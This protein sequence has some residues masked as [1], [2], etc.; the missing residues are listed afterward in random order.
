MGSLSLEEKKEKIDSF[1]SRK[2][3]NLF[4]KS[5]TKDEF[6]SNLEKEKPQKIQELFHKDDKAKNYYQSQVDEYT[7]KFV[8]ENNRREEEKRKKEIQEEQKNIETIIETNYNEAKNK[9]NINEFINFF[10]QNEEIKNL[11]SKK[12][13][14]MDYYN[15]LISNYSVKYLNEWKEKQNEIDSFFNDNYQT[16]F[17]EIKNKEELQTKLEEEGNKFSGIEYFENKKQEKL[18]QFENEIE[19]IKHKIDNHFSDYEEESYKKDSDIEFGNFF[20]DKKKEIEEYLNKDEINNYYNDELRKNKNKFKKYLDDENQKQELNQRKE[21]DQIFT[22]QYQNIFDES[23]NKGDLKSKLEETGRRFSGIKYFENKKEEK[24]NQYDNEIEQ[25]KSIIKSHFSEHYDTSLQ[26]NTEND[27]INFFNNKKN[28]IQRYLTKDVISNLYNNELNKYK[29]KFIENKID[30]YF[31]EQYPEIYNVQNKIDLQNILNNSGYN[32]KEYFNKKKT[33]KLNNYENDLLP[34]KGKITDF[35]NNKYNQAFESSENEQQFKKFFDDNNSEI[36]IYI[37]KNNDLKAYYNNKISLETEKFQKF[38]KDKNDIAQIDNFFTLEYRTIFDESKDEEDLK[39]KLNE[40]GSKFSGMNYFETKKQEKLDQYENEIEQM[41]SRITNHFSRLYEESLEQNTENDFMNFFNTKK[42]EIQKYLTKDVIR[43]LY[44]NELNKH[45]RK[46]NE[47]KEN[48]FKQKQEKDIDNFFLEKYPKVYDVKNKNDL[49]NILNNSDFNGIDY[50][51][52]KKIEKLNSYENDL[53]PMKNAITDFIDNKYKKAFES[54]KNENE[55]KSYYENNNEEIKKYFHNEDLKT[56]FDNKVDAKADRFKTDF[57]LE[58]KKQKEEMDK[59]IKEQKQEE[60]NNKE[61]E[62]KTEYLNNL[63]QEEFKIQECFDKFR[64]Y[65]KVKVE[66]EDIEKEEDKGKDDDKEK[67]K[68]KKKEKEKEEEIIEM[69]LKK[70]SKTENFADKVKNEIMLYLKELLDDKTKKVN[71]LNI[72]LLGKTGAGKSTLINA[73][74]ELENTDKQLKTSNRKP[75]TMLTEY[76]SSDKIDFLRCGDSRGIELGKFG[77]ESVQEEA[78]KFIDE[79]LKTNNPDLYVHCIWYCTI[80][81]TDRFQDDECKLL[82]NLGNKYSMKEIPIIIV[83][84]KANSKQSYTNLKQNIEDNVF[85]FNYPFIPVIAKKLDDKEVMGLEELKEI[86]I[87]KAKDAVE[88]ACYQGVFKKL[89]VTSTEKFKKLQ[90]IIKEKIEEKA[91]I[92]IEKIEREGKLES[93]KNDLKEMFTYILDNYLSIKLSSSNEEYIVNNNIYSLEGEKM[94]TDLINDYLK[95]CEDYINK[96]YISI[97]EEKTKTLTDKILTEQINFNIT[98][99]NTIIL[100]SRDIIQLG[101]KPKIDKILKNKAN[102]YYL[103]NVFNVF[104]EIL[105]R[106]IPFCFGIFLKKYLKKLE[107][108]DKNM[109]EMIS[110]NIR[111]QFE[112]LEEKIKKYN[113]E[114]K[115]K[116]KKELATKKKMKE[117]EN[118]MEMSDAMKRYMEEDDD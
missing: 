51:N 56:Y 100:K 67:E 71:H 24:L 5:R 16:I 117:V 19:Q 74:M 53:N 13:E 63:E 115:E 22:Q 46:F 86:S 91:K 36:Q 85:N 50:F 57:E 88:S 99:K 59:R 23:K 40:K 118:G 93:L 25:I 12:K 44:N 103:K 8:E 82:E 30:K 109:K 45:K 14:N 96:S 110:Q 77:I 104:L 79:Q 43:N 75:E 21:I 33:E 94:I 113:D 38:I 107:K 35:I 114:I 108:E 98:N 81:I 42:N 32:G 84:T 48:L 72:L 31:K 97:L 26:Q 116:K 76:I 9:E 112:E 4:Q 65:L 60:Y 106:L 11:T 62:I 111:V 47:H 49:E 1:F 2:Y 10:E 61:E 89:I 80:P 27:F 41:K 55:F 101:I 34:I 105:K 3:N 7:K 29:N 6:K 20:N 83:G 78:E 95:F 18:N 58:Q 102:A 73:I 66:V 87:I 28:E 90:L 92:I 52:K 69:I 15:N 64:A 37:S 17:N 70:L 54:S 39:N 68:G